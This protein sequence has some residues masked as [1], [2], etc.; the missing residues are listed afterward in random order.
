[1]VDG[2]SIVADGP[3]SA[4]MDSPK[5]VRAFRIEKDGRSWRISAEA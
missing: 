4:V 2:G 1:L 5:L 3:P